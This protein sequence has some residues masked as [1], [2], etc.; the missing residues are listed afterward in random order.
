MSKC[1]K[2]LLI[3]IS[4]SVSRRTSWEADLSISRSRTCAERLQANPVPRVTKIEEPHA[5]EHTCSLFIKYLQFVHPTC[6]RVP[7]KLINKISPDPILLKGKTELNQ[8][9]LF[10]T[11]RRAEIDC[12]SLVSATRKNATKSQQVVGHC[13]FSWNK[14]SDE[15]FDIKF[16]RASRVS[17]QHLHMPRRYKVT[18]VLSIVI[19]TKRGVQ[20]CR[21]CTKRSSILMRIRR[22]R[23]SLQYYSA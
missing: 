15:M 22:R 4:T 17:P 9:I 19:L 12:C 3:I 21:F 11:R 10:H 20:D 23:F 1:K 13:S 8:D 2:W 6:T 18:Q 14:S 16:R 5:I 7:L